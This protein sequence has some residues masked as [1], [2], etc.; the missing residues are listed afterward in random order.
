M[1]IYIKEHLHDAGKWIYT[2]YASAWSKLGF[3][4][5][6]YRELGAIPQDSDYCVMA[7]DADVSLKTLRILEGANS[8]YLYVQPTLFPGHW[9]NHPNF[10]SLCNPE[11]R[12]HLN[13]MDNV[14]KWTFSDLKGYHNEWKNVRTIPLAFDSVNYKPMPNDILFD[15]CFIGGIANNGFNE[16]YQIMVDHFSKFKDSDLNCGF[17]VN[18]NLAHW[19]ENTIL[20]NTK[21]AIN[22]HDAYQRQLGLDTNERTFKSLGLTGFLISDKVTQLENLF[23]DVPTAATPEEMF[24]LVAEWVNKDLSE[25]KEKNREY[26]SKRHSYITRAESML[27]KW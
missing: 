10:I 14:Y 24:E 19:Q 7:T 11:T 27:E 9:G 12:K 23:P 4:V 21:I 3:E 18:N 16:K 1:R 17:F 2:G 20:Y 13:E 22:I 8:A 25:I 26:V 15:I 6:Y 5:E